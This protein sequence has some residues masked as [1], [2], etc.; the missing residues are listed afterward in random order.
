MCVLYVL[1]YRRRPAQ[2][3]SQSRPCPSVSIISGWQVHGGAPHRT[4]HAG[5]NAAASSW[6]RSHPCD[7]PTIDRVT[8][9]V[10]VSYSDPIDPIAR[11]AAPKSQKAPRR[12]FTRTGACGAESPR[13]IPTALTCMLMDGSPQQS[14]SIGDAHAPARAHRRT[15][16]Q[17]LQDMRHPPGERVNSLINIVLQ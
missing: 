17:Q 3:T 9:R 15:R 11:I 16:D 6:V 2:A 12:Q 8:V 14:A 10:R 7:P 13:R 1:T 5:A 4:R